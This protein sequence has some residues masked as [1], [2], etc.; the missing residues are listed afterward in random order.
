[1]EVK[2]RSGRPGKLSERAAGRIVRKANQNP[3]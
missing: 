2:R 1:V 3:V